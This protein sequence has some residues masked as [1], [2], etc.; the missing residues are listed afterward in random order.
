MNINMNNNCTF[1]A[2]SNLKSLYRIKEVTPLTEQANELLNGPIRN[3]DLGYLKNV[4]VNSIENNTALV[5]TIR[6]NV[7]RIANYY[8]RDSVNIAQ[9]GDTLLINSGILTS[10]FNT[11]P[12]EISNN[13][14]MRKSLYDTIIAN[15]K[16]N[17]IAEEKGL[18]KGSE[19][20][21]ENTPKIDTLA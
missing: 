17:V 5:E 10:T 16:G 3:S 8:E 4:T 15:I 11:N 20:I 12:K 6:E 9:R 7:E 2:A 19:Y 14:D 1:G 21:K 13:T 18:K